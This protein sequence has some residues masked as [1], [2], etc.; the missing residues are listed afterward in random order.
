MDNHYFVHTTSIIDDDVEIGE[1]TK[2][3]HF[4]HI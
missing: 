4:S 3:W 1:N 2:I